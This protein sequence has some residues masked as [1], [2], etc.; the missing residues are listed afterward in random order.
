[1]LDLIEG[2]VGVYFEN[3]QDFVV[4]YRDNAANWQLFVKNHDMLTV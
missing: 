4:V 1:L 2:Q 3:S